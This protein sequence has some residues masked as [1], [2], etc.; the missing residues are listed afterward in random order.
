MIFLQD[1]K[2]LDRVRRLLGGRPHEEDFFTQLAGKS[3]PEQAQRYLASTGA[4]FDE[5]VGLV[6][7]TSEQTISLHGKF[8]VFMN[9][10]PGEL[11]FTAY[12]LGADNLGLRLALA[13][14]VDRAHSRQALFPEGINWKGLDKHLVIEA[15]CRLAAIGMPDEAIER[16]ARRVRL[17]VDINQVWRV[18][19]E[20]EVVIYLNKGQ[21]AILD[22]WWVRF[23][24]S[25]PERQT[26]LADARIPL[27]LLRDYQTRW[28]RREFK[29]YRK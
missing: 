10:P 25:D 9:H 22:G 15:A 2:K 20:Y 8:G 12:N 7:Q 19:E 3:V 4:L 1:L 23:K 13:W 5:A 21:Q 26:C 16:Y 6:E 18:V 11:W 17:P 28:N 29:I 27:S 24:L 14:L